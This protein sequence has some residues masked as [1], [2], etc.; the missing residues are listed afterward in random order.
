M[1]LSDDIFKPDMP[2][3]IK[4]TP[5]DLANLEDLVRRIGWHETLYHVCDLLF[6]HYAAA[7]GTKQGALRAV[8]RHIGF[9]LPG[10]I[11][12]DQELK[13]HRPEAT[14]DADGRG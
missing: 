4:A 3:D 11:C 8:A 5:A 9:I 6:K 12:C 14:P 7:T 2:A 1:E 10:V 13:L